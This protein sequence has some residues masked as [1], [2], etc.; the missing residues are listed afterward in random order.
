MIDLVFLAFIGLFLVMGLRRPFIW[1]LVYIYIDVLAPQ[2]V[3]Y[4]LI[5]SVPVSLIAFAAAF[6]GW[7][8]FDN[9]RG[10]QLSYRQ[11]LLIAF[12]LYCGWTTT[13]AHFPEPA[14]DKWNWVWKA[15]VFAIFLPLTLTTRRRIEA[16]LLVL[17]LSMSII[18]I[19]PGIKVVF[20][21]G[22]YG[23]RLLLA[24]DNSGIYESS[25]LACMAI[26]IIP[27]MLWFTKHGTILPTDW[28]ARAYVGGFIFACLLIPVGT[29]AR[30][31][32]VCI[33]VLGLLFF[34]YV[35][36]K[37]LFGA[38]AAIAALAA[39][40]FLPASFTDRMST[41]FSFEQDESASTRV[42][43]WS[44]TV[45]YVL[46][47]PVGGGFDAYRANEF[48]Y[49]LPVET[50]TGNTTIVRE[51]EVTDRGRAYHS[52][53]FEVLG[54]QGFVGAGLWLLIQLTGLWEMLRIKRRYSRRE[55][56]EQQWPENKW[57]A[58]LATAMFKAHIIYLVG[59]LFTGI[60]YQPVMLMLIG[61]QIGFSTY[62]KR[63]ER[64]ALRA[65]QKLKKTERLNERQS[66]AREAVPG[67]SSGAP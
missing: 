64:D 58:P 40:P 8:M 59:A 61:I 1:V 47:K 66:F 43:V 63:T 38:F 7:L 6:G 45:D 67:L 16:A 24:N 23:T 46:K 19:G 57:Q 5:Q 10:T 50:K 32:L 49:R 36:H 42:A 9:K 48:T 3:G 15:L 37:L 27:F 30:T 41:I 51:T 55:D 44:W 13:F 20:G 34:R 22:G 12:L 35:K 29:E 54:E 28:R 53:Y 31:G 33:A 65:Q 60:A 18:I 14:A 52:A 2:R 17:L 4:G 11:G 62:V 25:V 56:P 26:A 21:G 39:I